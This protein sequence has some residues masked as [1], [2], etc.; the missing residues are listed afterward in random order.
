MASEENNG[1]INLTTFSGKSKG[2]YIGMLIR[3]IK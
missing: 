2:L 1:D 3:Q